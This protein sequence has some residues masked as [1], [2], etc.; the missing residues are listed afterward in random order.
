MIPVTVGLVLRDGAVLMCQRVPGKVYPLHWEFPGGKVEPNESLED[1]LRREI[2]EELAIEVVKQEEYF[3]E[4][5]T[6]SNGMT[7]DITYFLVRE[8]AGEPANLEFHAIEWVTN[9]TLNA[10]LHLT[11]NARILEKLQREGIPV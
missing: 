4:T 10:R 7:Y 9:E 6:Y 8:F 2:R 1:A 3:R 11:G 5:A